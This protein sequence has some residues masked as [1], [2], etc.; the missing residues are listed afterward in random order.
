M[1]FN[2]LLNGGH[3]GGDTFYR[4]MATSFSNFPAFNDFSFGV[5]IFYTCCVL[6]SSLNVEKMS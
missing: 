4:L 2:S 3:V 6:I 1:P 5:G